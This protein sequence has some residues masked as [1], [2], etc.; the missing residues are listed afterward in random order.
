MVERAPAMT[1]GRPTPPTPEEAE[2]QIDHTRAEIARTLDALERK[3]N[4]RYFVEKGFEMFRESVSSK[5]AINRSVAAIRNNPAPIA[6]IG[7]GTAWMIVSNTGLADRNT[8]LADRIGGDE[9]VGKARRRAAEA[10]SRVG[11][12]AGELA[13]GVAGKIGMGGQTSADEHERAL[14][15]VGHPVVDASGLPSEGWVHQAADRAQGALRSARD[16]GGAMLNRAGSFAG[17][18]AGR[19]AGHAGDAFRRYPL[20]A[21]GIAVFAGVLIAALVPLS[22]TEQDMIGDTREELWQKAQE[23]GQEAVSRVREAA[24]RATTRAVDAAA[25]AATE[26]VREE[27]RDEMDK[28]SQH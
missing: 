14:G 5:E 8:G 1:D 23:A 27:I 13:S 18:G 22:R 16:A 3:L 4:A 11:T 19:M 20:V 25:D 28:P 12:R 9:R 17:D 26:A 10:A 2:R 6:L 15:H 21:G 24:S 7:I